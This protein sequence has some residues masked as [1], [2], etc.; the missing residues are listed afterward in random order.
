MAFRLRPFHA[1]LT[2]GPPSL[3][4]YGTGSTGSIPAWP[5]WT[6]TATAPRTI[7]CRRYSDRLR[8]LPHAA[9]AQPPGRL[10][11]SRLRIYASAEWFADPAFTPS[12]T[13]GFRARRRVRPL[14]DVRP[15]AGPRREHGLR[16]EYAHSLRFKSYISYSTDRS[17]RRRE[18]RQPLA[19]GL[20]TFNTSSRGRWSRSDS[21]EPSAGYSFG[22]RESGPAGG[23]RPR[24]SRTLGPFSPE[25]RYSSFKLIVAIAF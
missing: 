18:R 19:H 13:R 4:L 5:A 22:N 6:S 7:S 20:G 23:P 24:G 2:A 1:R 8:L 25:V 17:A 9:L 16:L 14:D 10:S 12:S 3:K 11:S 15:R 21:P